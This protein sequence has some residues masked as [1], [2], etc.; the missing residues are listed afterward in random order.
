MHR[1]R[2]R[3]QPRL[4]MTARSTRLVPILGTESICQS[5]VAGI[6]FDREYTVQSISRRFSFRS[7]DR[8]QLCFVNWIPLYLICNTAQDSALRPV[9]PT[10]H[11]R[12]I[13]VRMALIITQPPSDTHVHAHMIMRG[14]RLCKSER[15]AHATDIS[16][17]V[18]GL[19]HQK[20]EGDAVQL[21]KSTRRAYFL[22]YDPYKVYN[23]I[24]HQL[25][26]SAM[27]QITGDLVPT[28]HVE[29]KAGWLTSSSHINKRIP[30][31]FSGSSTTDTCVLCATL[32]YLH[33]SQRACLYLRIVLS[34]STASSLRVMA[35]GSVPGH[36]PSAATDSTAHARYGSRPAQSQRCAQTRSGQ[37]PPLTR[38][39]LPP[40]LAPPL[41]RSLAHAAS[42]SRG[43][44]GL[45]SRSRTRVT[46]IVHR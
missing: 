18:Q 19:S 30:L 42:V 1:N 40:R 39:L 36:S 25:K 13:I 31:C 33:K 5:P 7:N 22:C 21:W 6:V 12:C 23:C 10:R 45:P 27:H 35:T 26:F 28:G 29:E 16:F 9:G 2:Y 8:L 17:K 34:K 32:Y 14:G 15:S 44:S 46:G 41:P 20:R 43:M 11:Y 37:V 4:M 3:Y 24:P 38:P